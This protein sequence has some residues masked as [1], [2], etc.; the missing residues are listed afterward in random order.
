MGWG[1]SVSQT[2]ERM[3]PAGQTI[4][5]VETYVR[6]RYGSLWGV[7]FQTCGGEEWPVWGGTYSYYR[8]FNFN[9]EGTKALAYIS[10]YNEGGARRVKFHWVS[11]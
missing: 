6:P 11:T 5:G 1:S 2:E 7:K 8:N 10:G 3:I 4:S 9:T